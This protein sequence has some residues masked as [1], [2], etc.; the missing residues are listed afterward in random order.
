MTAC[1]LA[2]CAFT[3]SQGAS[4]CVIINSRVTIILTCCS[5][6]LSEPFSCNH[7]APDFYRVFIF[8]LVKN[9]FIKYIASRKVEKRIQEAH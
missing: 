7:F 8:E 1:V 2:D 9:N 5:Q 4:A 6:S 3:S